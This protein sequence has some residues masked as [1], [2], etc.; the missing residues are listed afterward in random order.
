MSGKRKVSDLQA[1]VESFAR[2][3]R[4]LTTENLES[5]PGILEALF[6]DDAL[7]DPDERLRLAER[8][9]ETIV[10]II[11]DCRDATDRHVG[12]VLFAIEDDLHNMSVTDRLTHMK[13]EKKV[14]LF[15]LYYP[16]RKRLLPRVV[17]G[18][19]KE[20][21]S[22]ALPVS[23][24]VLS[25][26]AQQAARQL[27]RY[28][29]PVLVCIDAYSLCVWFGFAVHAVHHAALAVFRDLTRDSHSWLQAFSFRDHFFSHPEQ[30]ADQRWTFGQKD[31]D[32]HLAPYS[33][34]SESDSALRNYAY[35]HRYLRA[36]LRD[37]TGRDYLRESLPSDRWQAVQAGRPFAPGWVD[38]LLS[39]LAES[40]PDTDEVFVANLCQDDEGSDLHAKWLEL[41]SAPSHTRAER[42]DEYAHLP[43]DQNRSEVAHDLL[44]LC[45]A[46]QYL[47]PDET[48]RNAGGR[49]GST[50]L[51]VMVNG[52]YECGAP[53]AG[54]GSEGRRVV[55]TQDAAA[56]YRDIIGRQPGRY[57]QSREDEGPVWFDDPPDDYFVIVP[58]GVI[59][60][61]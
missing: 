46:L 16:R 37:R 56:L 51:Q 23:D 22:G 8:V 11:E 48:L 29:Q 35:F 41:L 59:R 43:T 10:R 25:A 36:L 57:S 17:G 44:Q 20:F 52:L 55:F 40:N 1:A 42:R 15:P 54:P 26:K 3:A 9:R 2:C 38:K 24:V 28:A 39:V 49:F 21:S 13:G 53:F 5:L 32:A 50:V 31:V 19:R 47:F 60:G 14:D 34:A 45:I 27:Y 6:D 58:P 30:H 7:A 4:G 18:L 12:N 33:S 61:D